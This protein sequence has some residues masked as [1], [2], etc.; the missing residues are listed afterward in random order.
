WRASPTTCARW[1]TSPRPSRP[2]RPGAPRLRA[3]AREILMTYR[4][5]ARWQ[6]RDLSPNPLSEAVAARAAAGLELLDLT[7]SNPTA[8]GLSFPEDWPGLLL[9]TEGTATN[10]HDNGGAGDGPGRA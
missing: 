1:A 8:V 2:D 9:G 10:A 7:V 3:A 5:P 4:F 6:G